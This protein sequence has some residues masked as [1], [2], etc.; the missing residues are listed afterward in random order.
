MKRMLRFLVKE[1]S[2]YMLSGLCL[3]F[4]VYL[5]MGSTTGDPMKTI[6]PDLTLLGS[7]KL[8]EVLVTLAACVVFRRLKL[9]NDGLCLTL[10][11]VVLCMDPT[12][13]N[14]RFHAAGTF[15]GM[16]VNGACLALAAA[17]LWMLSKVGG[18]PITFAGARGAVVGAAAIYLSA[19]LFDADFSPAVR[20][21]APSQD[22]LYYL[23]W[24]TPFITAL[25]ARKWFE[26][27]VAPRQM[28][29]HYLNT[30]LTYGPF[31]LLVRHLVVMQGVYDVKYYA[32]NLAPVVLGIAVLADKTFTQ[33][34][35]SV[36]LA[37]VA[38]G[39]AAIMMS[40]D[41]ASAAHVV[42]ANGVT[43]TPVH[44]MAAV[45]LVASLWL[46]WDTGRRAYLYYAL[47]VTMPLVSGS[48]DIFDAVVHLKPAFL[49]PLWLATLIAAFRSRSFTDVLVAGWTTLALGLKLTS[50]DNPVLLGV[51]SHGA[52]WWLIVVGKAYKKVWVDECTVQ[53]ASFL[54]GTTFVGMHCLEFSHGA[55]LPYFAVQVVLFRAMGQRRGDAA[56]SNSSAGMGGLEVGLRSW[57]ALGHVDFL[58]LAKSFGGVGMMG[59]AFVGLGAGVWISFHREQ[60]LAWLGDDETAA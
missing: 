14:T 15:V 47:L 10:V 55:L 2:L 22:H 8:Y 30:V 40:G 38:A 58:A 52:I 24:L 4:G 33:L 32:A 50:W 26:E 57:V 11:A 44:L 39:W 21:A 9:E 51:W 18:L 19:G 29:H 48:T 54:M 37:L 36:P 6:V 35:A 3:L 60:L 20:H 16:T 25:A 7:M 46:F 31:M 53:L 28:R 23:L 49:V 56:L 12:L 42:L 1:G 45:N 34:R 13:F 43:L 59:L 5:L 41:A 27:A 17:T